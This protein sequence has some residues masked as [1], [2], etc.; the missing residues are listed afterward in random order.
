MLDQVPSFPRNYT[1]NWGCLWWAFCGLLLGGALVAAMKYC[2]EWS[3]S[4][5]NDA[6][7]PAVVQPQ[8]R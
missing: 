1:S 8:N 7:T 4:L 5:L 3:D 2:T 6:E